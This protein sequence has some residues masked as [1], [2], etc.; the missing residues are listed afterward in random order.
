MVELLRQRVEAAASGREAVE[1][2][3]V[4]DRS[5]RARRPSR[6]HRAAPQASRSSRETEIRRS[7]TR[8]ET[9]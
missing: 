8:N 1:C 5:S 4:S 9:A 3:D 2:R 7:S 6:T